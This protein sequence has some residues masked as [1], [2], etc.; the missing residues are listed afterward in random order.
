MPEQHALQSAEKSPD[1]GPVFNSTLV[2]EMSRQSGLLT[3][4]VA[5]RLRQEELLAEEQLGQ[6]SVLGCAIVSLFGLGASEE[7]RSTARDAHVLEQERLQRRALRLQRHDAV[8]LGTSAVK[9]LCLFMPG[10]VGLGLTA[11]VFTLDQIKPRSSQGEMIVDGLLGLTKGFATRGVMRLTHERGLSPGATGIALGGF[12]RF[13]DSALNRTTYMNQQG[14]LDLPGASLKIIGTTANPCAIAMDY[15]LFRGASGAIGQLNRRFGGAIEQSPVIKNMVTGQTFGVS[16]GFSSEVVRQFSEQDFDPIRLIR[17]PLQRGIVDGF[18]AMPGGVIAARMNRAEQRVETRSMGD[19]PVVR[20]LENP[21]EVLIA[22]A[23]G[24]RAGPLDVGRI[25]A[26]HEELGPFQER[27]EFLP[28]LRSQLVPEREFDRWS[29]QNLLPAESPQRVR[30]Y[31]IDGTELIVTEAYDVQLGRLRSW[32]LEN[33]GAEIPSTHEL[34]PIR[35]R[36]LP[37]ETIPALRSTLKPELISRVRMLDEEDHYDIFRRQSEP[38]YR[39]SLAKASSDGEIKLFRPTRSSLFEEDFLHESMHLVKWRMPHVSY[40]FDLAARLEGAPRGYFANYYSKE[41]MDDNF[42]VHAAEVM[43]NPNLQR[44]ELM[45]VQAPLRAATILLSFKELLADIPTPQWTPRHEIINR[46]VQSLL[47][48]T[49]A[50]ARQQLVT[51]VNNE[52]DQPTMETATKLLLQ[53]GTDGDLAA[54]NRRI[55]Q[56]DLSLEPVSRQQIGRIALLREGVTVLGLNSLPV[57]DDVAPMLA[58]MPGLERLSLRSTRMTDW[59]VD[60]LSRSETLSSLDLANI[61]GLTSSVVPSLLQMR[62]VT[63][64]NLFGTGLSS[65]HLVSLRSGLPEAGIHD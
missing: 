2:E 27:E 44:A 43:A 39:G 3:D 58:R 55:P 63:A 52:T 30:V 6:R 14:E 10:Y 23:S 53:I 18:S 1:S 8:E 57:G 12:T 50:R 35:N 25:R 9:T 5:A 16:I 65:D 37:E 32:Y 48:P 49:L 29:Q 64:L 15:A 11:A 47:E 24:E 21:G 19:Q 54:I 34:Y 33:N 17:V 20:A 28:K 40:L 42:S 45:A 59:G 4:Q 22:G 38:N 61:R 62:R 26:L 7:A 46:N 13:S 51:K 36:L 56:L 60:Q 31:N 41:G